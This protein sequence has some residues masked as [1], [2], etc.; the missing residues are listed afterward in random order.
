MKFL[1]GKAVDAA[2]GRK[3]EA[4]QVHQVNVE[5]IQRKMNSCLKED[6]LTLGK[7]MDHGERSVFLLLSN[8]GNFCAECV[9]VWLACCG[10]RGVIPPKLYFF[11]KH[12]LALLKG[13]KGI[14]FRCVVVYLENSQVLAVALDSKVF[15]FFEFV[16]LEVSKHLVE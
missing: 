16:V 8:I 1:Y 5:P 11:C 9:H 10:A 2:A 3:A 15:R 6:I 7:S 13:L 4:F 14:K 12:E